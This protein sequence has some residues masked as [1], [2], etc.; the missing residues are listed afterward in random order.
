MAVTPALDAGTQP[1]SGWTGVQNVTYAATQSVK[2][3]TRVIQNGCVQTQPFLLPAFVVKYDV[4]GTVVETY[5]HHR[6]EIID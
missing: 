3:D 2:V 5:K 6:R 1:C 4:E